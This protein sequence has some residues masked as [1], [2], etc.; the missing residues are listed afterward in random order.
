MPIFELATSQY[1]SEQLSH[2]VRRDRARE[3]VANYAKSYLAHAY[4]QRSGPDYSKPEGG[5]HSDPHN[6]M[7]PTPILPH[8]LLQP[9]GNNGTRSCKRT[10][11]MDPPANGR[12][13]LD[14]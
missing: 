5:E 4:H 12:I 3:E 6:K 2:T 1:G 11:E 10:R 7:D 9:Y 8:L 14:G 13:M